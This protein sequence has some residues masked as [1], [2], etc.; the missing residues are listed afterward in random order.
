M[1]E[2]KVKWNK[3]G[4]NETKPEQI[5]KSEMKTTKREKNGKQTIKNA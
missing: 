1:K 3:T 4:T 2:R 5:I